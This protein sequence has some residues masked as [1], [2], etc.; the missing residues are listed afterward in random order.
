MSVAQTAIRRRR[1]ANGGFAH[2]PK[3]K[4]PNYKRRGG[5]VSS[6]IARE[7]EAAMREQARKAKG[8]K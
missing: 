4:R 5:N 1:Q 8:K 3:N 6:A 2:M 7:R